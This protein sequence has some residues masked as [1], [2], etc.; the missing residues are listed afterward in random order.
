MKAHIIENGVVVNTVLVDSLTALPGVTLVDATAGSIGWLYDGETFTDPDPSRSDI[1]SQMAND[2]RLER[3]R[4]L[5]ETVDTLNV[6]R[7]AAMTESQQTAWAEYRQALLDV[8]AQSGFPR[9]IQW[10]TKPE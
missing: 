5:S 7:W 8:S 9:Q 4:L 2:A 6:P 3:N 10:P 1:D